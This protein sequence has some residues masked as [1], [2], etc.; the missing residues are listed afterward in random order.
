MNKFLLPNV[1]PQIFHD[2]DGT[3]EFQI[4]LN[5]PGILISLRSENYKPVS[6]TEELIKLTNNTAYLKR[7]T[8]GTI[9]FLIENSIIPNFTFAD[10]INMIDEGIRKEDEVVGSFTSKNKMKV[11]N[12]D[13][14]VQY[15]PKFLPLYLKSKKISYI[16][17][18]LDAI[19]IAKKT[20][21][22][23]DLQKLIQ[24]KEEKIDMFF[25]LFQYPLIEINEKFQV[26]KFNE[27]T[28]K[29]FP[30]LKKNRKKN[31]L[32]L[33]NK[34]NQKK[35]IR[36]LDIAN[37][38][39]D[40]QLILFEETNNKTNKLKIKFSNLNN[41]HSKRMNVLISIEN[42]NQQNEIEQDAQRKAFLLQVPN[43]LSHEIESNFN[44]FFIRYVKNVLR[45]FSF[46]EM[47]FIPFFKNQKEHYILTL[48]SMDRTFISHKQF[49]IYVDLFG[50]I[51][52]KSIKRMPSKGVPMYFSSQH[53]FLNEAQYMFGIP[54]YQD[55]IQIGVI[56]YSSEKKEIEL[57]ESYMLYS[58]TVIS[59]QLL[60]SQQTTIDIKRSIFNFN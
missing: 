1:A 29:I 44:T 13:V 45:S 43:Q 31:F 27:E 25:K 26:E 46:E 17:F 6:I 11:Y 35:I 19:T 58:M 23:N 47:Y 57:D 12:D 9:T 37:G 51:L 8:I 52:K 30:K 15:R 3:I 20:L 40:Q 24:N 21:K 38:H 53:E 4:P 39:G 56:I 14:E 48:S 18:Y 41:R 7:K 59:Y 33:W 54:I 28:L 32:D 16:Y 60:I 10:F 49:E 2:K 5:L 55:E 22:L 50:S 34:D 36:S 42:L